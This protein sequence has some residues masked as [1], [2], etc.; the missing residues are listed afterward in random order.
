MPVQALII[1]IHTLRINITVQTLQRVRV[2][3]NVPQATQPENVPEIEVRRKY[4]V[5]ERVCEKMDGWMVGYIGGW[6]DG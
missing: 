2:V 1:Y 3:W 4:S 6:M 5:S